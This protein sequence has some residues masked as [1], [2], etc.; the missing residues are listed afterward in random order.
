MSEKS[1]YEGVSCGVVRDLLPLYH[2]E[3]CGEESSALVR[4][5]LEGCAACARMLADIGDIPPA[6]PPDDLSTGVALRALG[7]RM[8]RS[9]LLWAILYPLLAL[10]VVTIGFRLH[11]EW[12]VFDSVPAPAS[13]VEVASLYRYQSG[14]LDLQLRFL[15]GRAASGSGWGERWNNDD[16]SVVYLQTIRPRF[17]ARAPAPVLSGNLIFYNSRG[18]GGNTDPGTTL[19]KLYYGTPEDCILIWEEGMDVPAATEEMER[20]YT[21]ELHPGVHIYSY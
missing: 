3:V 1:V 8:R 7:R 11:Q 13:Q 17:G 19:R 12:W 9:K 18:P 21:G 15:D 2:D 16:P 6:A 10:V 5:H 14:A 4:A 20:E